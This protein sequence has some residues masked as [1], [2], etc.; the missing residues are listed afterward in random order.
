MK[1]KGNKKSYSAR[2]KTLA[3]IFTDIENDKVPANIGKILRTTYLVALEKDPNDLSKLQPVGVPS[4]IR[5]IAAVLI[6]QSHCSSFAQYLLPF[7][8]AIGV[9]GGIDMI[10]T[11]IR[12]GVEKSLHPPKRKGTSQPELWCL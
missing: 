3:K 2:E 9:N 12:L 10:T 7:N 11:G 4:A 6:L 1:K 5:R 8:Y